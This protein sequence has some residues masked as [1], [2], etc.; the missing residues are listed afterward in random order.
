MFLALRVLALMQASDGSD[1]H[2]DNTMLISDVIKES[3]VRSSSLSALLWR[4]LL[5][6]NLRKILLESRSSSGAPKYDS[7]QALP[8]IASFQSEAT[9]Y[10]KIIQSFK[11]SPIPDETA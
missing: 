3:S 11:F 10:N 5:W 8:Q 7:E 2:R 1:N 6:V 4:L 9:S